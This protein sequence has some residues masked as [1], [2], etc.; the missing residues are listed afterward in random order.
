MRILSALWIARV[1]AAAFVVIGLFWGTF[2]AAV[3]DIKASLGVNDAI[4]GLLLLANGTGLVTAMWVA[5][6]IDRRLGERGLQASCA[7]FGA[8]VILPGLIS[9]PIVFVVA[10]AC[11]GFFSGLCDIL[12]NARVSELEARHRR[13]LM[14]SSHAMF[15]VAY[16]AAAFWTGLF[17]DGGFGPAAPLALTSLLILLIATRL[18]APVQDIEGAEIEAGRL[19]WAIVLTCGAIVLVAFMTEATV[20]TWSALHI[21]RTLGGDPLAGALGPVMLGLTMAVGRFAGQGIS[22]RFEDTRVI[23]AASC[24]TFTG[25]LIAA[26]APSP[27]VA[28]LG[29][30]ILGLGVSVIGPLG[31]ALAGRSVAPRHRTEAISKAAVMG[32]SGFFIAPLLVGMVSQVAGLRAAYIVVG[33]LI[34]TAVV[35]VAVLRR[36]ERANGPPA[37]ATERG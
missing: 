22:E 37:S 14:N 27:A 35:W 19:P 25:A 32:F 33:G 29:F 5:P 12:M 20:E 17:R 36:L 10:M 18:R 11:L 8:L 31:I 4:F 28:Y 23:I 21:E 30:G 3:P 26:L 9:H 16:A 1:P 34:L 2:A 15:S 24:L 7:S 13:P 6:H